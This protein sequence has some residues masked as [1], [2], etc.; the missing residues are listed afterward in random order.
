MMGKDIPYKQYPKR[1]KM[2]TQ[3][4]NKI[5][6]KTKMLLEKNKKIL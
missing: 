2:I 5:D 1:A 3:I 4:L 6:F